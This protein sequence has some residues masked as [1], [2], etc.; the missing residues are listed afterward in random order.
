MY[1]GQHN[2]DFEHPVCEGMFYE[3]ADDVIYA[4]SITG[5]YLESTIGINIALSL[6]T[7]VAAR[8][9]ANISSQRLEWWKKNSRRLNLF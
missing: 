3:K 1:H 4:P 9:D 5:L 7:D 8:K 2:T 6:L